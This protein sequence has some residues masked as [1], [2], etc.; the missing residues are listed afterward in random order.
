MKHQNL[1]IV[2]A[3]ITAA[4][5]MQEHGDIPNPQ[6]SATLYFEVLHA[7][8]LEANKSRDNTSPPSPS[9]Y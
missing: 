4:I 6:N 9:H 5:M 7:L 8:E 1:D 3:H 2:A